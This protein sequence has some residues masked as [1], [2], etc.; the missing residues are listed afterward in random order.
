MHSA[1]LPRA[2]PRNE[3]E[4]AADGLVGNPETLE[5]ITT[6]AEIDDREGTDS[7]TRRTVGVER[8]LDAERGLMIFEQKWGVDIMNA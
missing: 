8:W 7:G 2:R 1:S 3:M 6:T 4:E 5:G